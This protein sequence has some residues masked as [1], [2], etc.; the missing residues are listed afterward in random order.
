MA[1]GNDTTTLNTLLIDEQCIIEV[2]E[3]IT[4]LKDAVDSMYRTR[5]SNEDQRLKISQNFKLLTEFVEVV[6]QLRTKASVPE[7]QFHQCN[8]N[9]DVLD[10]LKQLLDS[11]SVI[12]QLIRDIKPTVQMHTIDTQTD[13]ALTTNPITNEEETRSYKNAVV[14]NT[15]YL[16]LQQSIEP[17]TS[18]EMFKIHQIVNPAQCASQDYDAYNVQP[19]NGMSSD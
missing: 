6:K 18:H 10:G 4:S 2:V 8:S 5:S 1:G 7:P 3:A 14:G 15:A 9:N 17:G 12:T 19:N 11:N 13:N 16:N